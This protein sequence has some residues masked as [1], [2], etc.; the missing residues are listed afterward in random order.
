M[1]CRKFSNSYKFFNLFALL[2]FSQV[3]FF[4]CAKKNQEINSEE[5]IEAKSIGDHK[6]FALSKNGFSEVSLPQNAD[7]AIKR[8]W[9]EAVRISFMAQGED[10]V[11]VSQTTEDKSPRIYALVNRL[12]LLLFSE[13]TI[14]LFDDETV[15]E[16][17]TADNIVFMNNTPIFSIYKNYFFNKTIE[18]SQ[19]ASQEKKSS[20][21]DVRKKYR[22]FLIEFDT[23]SGIFYPLLSCEN[24]GLSDQS[25]ITDY[26]WNGNQWLCSI[27]TSLPEKTE[28]SYIKFKPDT[29]LL[30]ISPEK[31]TIT[32]MPSTESEFRSAQK[33]QDFSGAP[34]RVKRLLASLPETFN[35][36]AEV[37]KAG[38]CSPENYF[39]GTNEDSAPNL[40]LATVQLSES[41][42]ACLFQD[43]TMYLSGALYGRKILKNGKTIAL[44]LP[45]LTDGYLYTDFGL[46]GGTLY[47]AWEETSFF[48]TGRAGFITVELGKLL[49]G[50]QDAK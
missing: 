11:L 40:P 9:T 10:N 50:E 31:A 3:A 19:L 34:E 17:Q 39:H 49:Y 46:S 12:G 35:F 24:L 38:G 14:T 30:S 47:A 23:E 7:A 16:N 8:P 27:K 28:F 33:P 26:F 32:A 2:I 13:K 6:W 37:K 42:V 36:Y 48:K 18:E 22:A 41:W 43:G 25:E 5:I 21:S 44:R 1:N 29:A 4:S 45:R 20:P 15:F